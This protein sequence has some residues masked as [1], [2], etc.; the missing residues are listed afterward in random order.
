MNCLIIGGSSGLG[1]SL[2]HKLAGDYHVVVTG[3]RD[4]RRANLQF[5]TL[6]L[7]ASDGLEGRIDQLVQK[8]P[9]I[10]LLIYAAG[11]Y[12]EGTITDLSVDQIHQMLNVGLVAALLV[13]RSL[14]AKQGDLAGFIAVTSTSQWTPRLL[15]PAYTAV[16]AGLAA[17][18]NSLSLDSRV[19]KTLVAGP[20]GM[21]TPFW[22]GTN[23]DISSMLDPDWVAAQILSLFEGNFSY[24]CGRI[25]RGPARAELQEERD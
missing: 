9:H 7:G 12:Q 11:F 6:D 22:A 19:A 3:R 13:T 25:L 1:L 21:A 15:E 16:K 14:L 4:P 5:E 20:A 10:D 8:L 2:A 23:K 17:F 24:R 18:A